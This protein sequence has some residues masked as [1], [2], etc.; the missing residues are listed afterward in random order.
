MARIPGIKRCGHGPP[1]G[2]NPA[3]RQWDITYSRTA[4]K[5]E[6]RRMTAQELERRT[7]ASRKPSRDQQIAVRP[8]LAARRRVYPRWVKQGRMGE[9]TGVAGHLRI[10][11][12]IPTGSGG[13]VRSSWRC[14]RVPSLLRR[15]Q[16]AHS[17][18]EHAE[19][20]LGPA[21]ALMYGHTRYGE[22]CRRHGPGERGRGSYGWR[23]Q[24]KGR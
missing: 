7:H 20:R 17:H 14:A 4:H 2:R 21:V 9:Y 12:M 5:R 23:P 24:K 15:S 22:A 11:P 8:Q 10:M 19:Q 13:E 16:V 1:R 18:S 6:T 3:L